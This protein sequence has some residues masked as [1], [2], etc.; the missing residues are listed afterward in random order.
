MS[1]NGSCNGTDCS[2]AGAMPRILPSAG[3]AGLVERLRAMPPGSL[4]PVAWLLAE[5]EQVEGGL[6]AVPEPVAP[7][8]TPDVM[9][10]VE[11]V[12]ER[13]STTPAWIYANWRKKLPFGKKLSRRQLRFSARALERHLDRTRGVA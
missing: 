2:D 8:N 1:G 4:V 6:V 9:L 5:L 12:A 13:I 10:T 7:T 11:Q 3:K